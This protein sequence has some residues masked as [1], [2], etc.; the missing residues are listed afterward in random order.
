MFRF[1]RGRLNQRKNNF[2]R[3]KI[4]RGARLEQGE[5]LEMTVLQVF[6]QTLFTYYKNIIYIY[7]ALSV[8]YVTILKIIFRLGFL[9]I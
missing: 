6:V 3:Q 8:T 1:N 2:N 7:S 4:S 5:G 9:R